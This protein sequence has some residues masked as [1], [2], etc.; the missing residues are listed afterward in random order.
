[1]VGAIKVHSEQPAILNQKPTMYDTTP[2]DSGDENP[3][4]WCCWKFPSLRD[5]N[6][7]RKGSNTNPN[8]DTFR[9]QRDEL[10]A[11]RQE[12]PSAPGSRR[13]SSASGLG[14][15]GVSFGS[16]K[17]SMG[18]GLSSPAIV[19]S[20]PFPNGRPGDSIAPEDSEVLDI[21]TK[22][23]QEWKVG[24]RVQL[25][26]FNSGSKS[27]SVYNEMNDLVGKLVQKVAV[28]ASKPNEPTKWMVEIEDPQPKIKKGT[29]KQEKEGGKVI[30][31]NS[32]RGETIQKDIPEKL[33]KT[34]GQD[35][36]IVMSVAEARFHTFDENPKSGSLVPGLSA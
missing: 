25:V 16:G 19:I 26:G 30:V 10:L 17:S 23:N 6:P 2:Q 12:S 34:K 27:N 4:G 35:G 15:S 20:P 33:L 11:H 29:D 18:S 1:M 28:D 21:V 24:D 36:K 3:Q 13:S 31:V 5:Y 8:K 9:A 7:F 32:N 14:G 22:D